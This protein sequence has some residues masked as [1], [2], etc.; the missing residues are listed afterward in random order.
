MPDGLID[1]TV[2]VA[3]SVQ[4]NQLNVQA[5]RDLCGDDPAYKKELRIQYKVGNVI[6]GKKRWKENGWKLL[7]LRMEN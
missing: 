6:L 5:T 7:C 3:K 4:N 1:T 2:L